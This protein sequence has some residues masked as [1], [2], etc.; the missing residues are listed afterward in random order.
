MIRKKLK[1][2]DTKLR[3][4]IMV[5]TW[6]LLDLSCVASAN[7]QQI[8][9]MFGRIF[10]IPDRPQKVYSTSPPVTNLLYAIDPEMLTGINFPVQ[11]IQKKYLNKIMQEL[12]VLGG[13]FGQANTPN[14]EMI[15]K[16]K[17][18]IIVIFK[19]NAAM[20]SIVDDT[21]RTIP[22]PV[23]Y[24]T[25]NSLSDYPEAMLYLGKVLGRETRAKKLAAYA[26]STLAEISILSRSIPQKQRVSVYYA[27]GIDG[28]STECDSSLHAELINLVGGRNVHRCLMRS[29]YGME[30]VSMEQVMLYN[31][32][33]ILA[34]EPA[35]YRSVFSDPR[36]KSIKAIK[37]KRVYLI[38]REPFN[39]FDRPPSFMRFLGAKWLANLLYPDHYKPDMI[40][41]SQQFFR[42]FLGV[43]VSKNDMNQIIYP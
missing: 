42:L 19:H 34:I 31:P 21:M 1:Y 29:L 38:P 4:L 18:D 16:T 40:K 12:P 17:P 28:L 5:L 8:T 30:K 39:W 26:R 37:D 22:I 3:I 27:E 25:L 32:E 43:D 36:W 10:L 9:D 41:E 15:L 33:V 7:A 6:L 13:W 20:S 11:K 2:D 23:I 14:I 35:F 24:V